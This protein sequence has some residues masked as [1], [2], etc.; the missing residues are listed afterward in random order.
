LVNIP[1]VFKNGK[2][3]VLVID[4]EKVLSNTIGQYLLSMGY[5]VIFADDAT[6]GLQI[7]ADNQPYAIILGIN[8]NQTDSLDILKDLKQN[9][10]TK[11]IPVILVSII[12]DKNLGYTL[13]IFDYLIKPISSEN[14]SPSLFKLTNLVEKKIHKVMVVDNDDLELQKYKDVKDFDEIEIE[15]VKESGEALAKIEES[16]PD[17][18]IIDLTITGIDGLTL[19]HMLKL[20]SETKKI[21]II[22]SVERE[23]ADDVKKYLTKVVDDITL[24]SN[25]N[26]SEV[27]NS[28]R[29]WLEIQESIKHSEIKE[30]MNSPP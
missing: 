25:Q 21:P 14:L 23:L 2:R 5:G 12:A 18:I 4:S 6:Q 24:K 20:N 22:I 27:I 11:S 19:S 29:D 7:A 3:L 28:V 16:Q 10:N 8:I 26:I 9:L 17:L 1:S 13:D 30:I 15:L